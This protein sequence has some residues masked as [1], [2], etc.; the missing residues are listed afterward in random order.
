MGYCTHGPMWM[1]RGTQGD[2]ALSRGRAR[3]PAWR[4]C[5][6]WMRIYIYYIYYFIKY[7]GLPII[8][9]QIINLTKPAY[10]I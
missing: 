6:M 3:L 4:R 1:R 2:V 8:G 10:L 9:R 5:D 7:I